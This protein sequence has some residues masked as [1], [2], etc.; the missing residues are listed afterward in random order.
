VDIS[1]VITSGLLL[2][3][4]AAVGLVPAYLI[5]RRKERHALRVRWDLPLYEMCKDCASAVRQFVHLVRRYDRTADREQHYARVDEQHARIRTLVQQI[6][7]L[8][9]QDLQQAAREVEHHA[10]WVRK[11]CE[12]GKDELAEYYADLPPEDRLRESM[13][14]LF[15]AAR[16]Q[17]GVKNPDDVASDEPIDPRFEK[18]S[19]SEATNSARPNS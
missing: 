16:R 8:G 14:R 4:G 17:L 5:E 7:I 15:I 9:S 12:G 2:T 3:I 6:R 19:S 18:R 11:V 13:L 1:T 10:W